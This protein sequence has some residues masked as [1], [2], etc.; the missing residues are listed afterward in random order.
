[1]QGVLPYLQENYQGQR[2]PKRKRDQFCAS[3]GLLFYRR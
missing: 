2:T 3:L 1:M